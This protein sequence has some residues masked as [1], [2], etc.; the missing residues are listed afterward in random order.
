[1]ALIIEDGTIVS[2]ANSYASLA[3]LR[4]YATARGITLSAT[5]ATV[6][7]MAIKA[8]DYLEAKRNQYQGEKVSNT[9]E[10]QFPRYNLIIDGFDFPA[11][12]IPNELIKAQCQLVLEVNA[13][14]I[15]MPTLTEAPIKKEVIGPIETEYA[16][17]AGNSFLPDFQAV[18]SLLAPLYKDNQSGFSLTSIRI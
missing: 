11:N 16:V 12:D 5:D 2:G 4:A 9:Q 6:E 15:L 17:S 10:L 13:G 7:V 8:M 18:E 1:M 3:V 14:N